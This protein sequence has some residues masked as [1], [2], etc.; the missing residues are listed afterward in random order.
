MNLICPLCN[1]LEYY[2]IRCEKCKNKMADKGRITDYYD[3]YSPYLEMSITEL[4]D[5]VKNNQCLHLFTCEYCGNSKELV[6]DKI[7]K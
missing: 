5:G 4:V 3:N 1:G 6:I 7:T 2:N